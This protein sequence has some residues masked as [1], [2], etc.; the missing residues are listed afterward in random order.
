MKLRAREFLLLILGW[1]FVAVLLVGLVVVYRSRY[2]GAADAPGP[3][4]THTV[5]FTQVTARGLYPAAEALALTWQPDAQLASTTATWPETAADLVGEPTDWVFR[6]YSPAQ[7]GYYFVTVQPDGQAHGIE[8]AQKVDLPPPTIPVDAWRVD[9]V[10]ALATWLDHGG[11]AMLG[12]RPGIEVSAQLNVPAEGGEPT[13]AVVGFDP[14]S[15]DFLT[16]MI[17]ADSGQVLQ[18]V[19]PSPE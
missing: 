3:S 6:F 15:D 14:G 9:S 1:L 5:V 4:P 13:W 12:T 7:Q 11:G 8:H 16:V 17:H 2:S 18:T 10:E 19:K